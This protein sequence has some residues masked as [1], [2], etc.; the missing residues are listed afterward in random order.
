[1]K[2]RHRAYKI[3]ISNQVKCFSLIRI[4]EKE[5]Q[6]N[7]SM[8]QIPI[9]KIMEPHRYIKSKTSGFKDLDSTNEIR[10]EKGKQ[11][12]RPAFKGLQRKK[13]KYSPY[14]IEQD[15]ERIASTQFK[16]LETIKSRNSS[17]KNKL[18]S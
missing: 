4:D 9:T 14:S 18:D 16:P 17:F 12:L 2:K 3:L 5:D 11:V 1:M 7:L 10:L 8:A 13:P 15:Y 6:A